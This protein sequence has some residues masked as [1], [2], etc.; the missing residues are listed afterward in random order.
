[1]QVLAYLAIA[2]VLIWRHKANIRRLLNGE[3]PRFGKAGKTK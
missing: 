2:A 3:E 1:M